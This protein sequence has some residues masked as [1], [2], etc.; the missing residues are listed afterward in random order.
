MKTFLIDIIDEAHQKGSVHSVIK[1]TYELINRSY[2]SLPRT[3]VEG[4][5]QFCSCQ[6]NK[7]TKSAPK[8]NPIISNQFMERLQMDLI[9]MRAA[10]NDSDMNFIFHAMDQFTK[11]HF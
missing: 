10:P 4:F 1:R 5:I 9:D 8:L 3:F 11:F 7:G 2:C 6:V